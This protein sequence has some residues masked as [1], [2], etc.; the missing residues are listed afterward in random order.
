MRYAQILISTQLVVI[1]Q[2]C[3]AR[4]DLS[5]QKNNPQRVGKALLL[6]VVMGNRGC[7]YAN[8]FLASLSGSALSIG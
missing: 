7:G 5:L 3:V 2:E 6:R 1:I 8:A 4:L